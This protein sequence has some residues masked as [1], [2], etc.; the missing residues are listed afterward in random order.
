ML[1]NTPMMS[2]GPVLQLWYWSSSFSLTIWLL[3]TVKV[4]DLWSSNVFC[5]G[6]NVVFVLTYRFDTLGGLVYSITTAAALAPPTWWLRD[7]IV[8]LELVHAV[9]F[10]PPLKL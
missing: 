6:E 8:R 5:H 10:F 2:E 7:I 3:S 4:F 1:S 9:F